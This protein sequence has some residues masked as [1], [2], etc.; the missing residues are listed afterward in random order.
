M[1][2]R[3]TVFRWIACHKEFTYTREIA[4]R[5]AEAGDQTKLATGSGPNMKV[6]RSSRPIASPSPQRAN[7]AMKNIPIYA[8]LAQAFAVEG[9]DTHFT[10]MGDGNMHWAAAMKSLDGMSTFADRHEHCVCAM[11]IG[12]HSATGK[13]GVASVTCGPGLT[14]ITT[15]LAVAARAHIPLVVFAGEAPI[16][17]Q[18]VQSGDRAA[19]LCRRCWRALHFGAQSGAHVPICSRGVLRRPPSDVRSSASETLSRMRSLADYTIITRESEFSEA[20][21]G[22]P[23]YPKGTRLL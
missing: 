23:L 17:R 18:M 13:V 16:N 21:G 11:A 1:P 2:S 7:A 14:Q 12:Y 10:L 4:A 3:A 6:C 22:H 15:A 19:A 5:T 20:T 8:A 9:V